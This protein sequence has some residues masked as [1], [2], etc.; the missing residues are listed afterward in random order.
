MVF[1]TS[2]PRALVQ[3]RRGACARCLQTAVQL[4]RK[5]CSKVHIRTCAREMF[6]KEYD[7]GIN[8]NIR[9]FNIFSSPANT[10][11]AQL[12]AVYHGNDAALDSGHTFTP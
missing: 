6:A 4:R 12:R 10:S 7:A 2:D 11:D 1:L 8:I 3:L 9:I 5:A